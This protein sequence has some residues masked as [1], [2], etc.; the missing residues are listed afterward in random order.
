M[1]QE[2]LPNLIHYITQC[3]ENVDRQALL[4]LRTNDLIRSIEYALGMQE[5]MCGVVTM[6]KC[7]MKSVYDY[8]I[9]V[10][11]L[12]HHYRELRTLGLKP[13]HKRPSGWSIRWV[14]RA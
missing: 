10:S 3:L 11:I 1:F 8:E 13:A 9:K 2:E 4:V 14:E 6:T 5:R 7:M 12:F